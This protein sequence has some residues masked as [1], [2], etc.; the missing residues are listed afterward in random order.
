[1]IKSSGVAIVLK[2]K[3]HQKFA[4][5]DQK[6]SWYGCINLLSYGSAEESI[7]PLESSNIANE[8]IRSINY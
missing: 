5:I 8:F 6:V 4:V 2:S 3:I 7:M 1:M